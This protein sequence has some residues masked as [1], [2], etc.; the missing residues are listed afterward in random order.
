MPEAV[1]FK[2]QGKVHTIYFARAEAKLPVRLASGEVKLVTWGRRQ[3]ENSEMPLGGWAR[4]DAVHGGKWAQ[5]LPKPVRVPVTKFMKTDYEGRVHWYDVTSGQS[6][7]GLLAHCEQ[8]YR[9]YIVTIVPELLD[10]C[11]DRWPRIVVH[12]PS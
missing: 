11:H 6:I 4:L 3:H 1:I 9:L 8:E 10:V 5:Y 7:Q 2:H 12:A